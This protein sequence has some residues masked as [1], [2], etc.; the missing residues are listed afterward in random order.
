MCHNKARNERL[1]LETFQTGQA[2][3]GGRGQDGQAT[4]GEGVLGWEGVR[5]EREGVALSGQSLLLLQIPV[6]LILLQ[7]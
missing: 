6:W 2:G 3:E 4:S 7:K 1:E 5:R